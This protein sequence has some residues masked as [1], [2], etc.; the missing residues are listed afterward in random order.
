MSI[1]DCRDK[2]VTYLND[3][4]SPANFTAIGLLIPVT[5]L[6]ESE[7]MKV[8]VAPDPGKPSIIDKETRKDS[9]KIHAIQIGIIQKVESNNVQGDDVINFIES[10]ADTF[11]DQNLPVGGSPIYRS[12]GVSYQAVYDYMKLDEDNQILSI[13]EVSYQEF[14]G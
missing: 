6:E 1:L 8:F 13:I 3:N 4:F 9:T 2:V 10:V 12:L 5:S 14:P 11:H 7:T